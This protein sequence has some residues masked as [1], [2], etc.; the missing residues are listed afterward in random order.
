MLADF[1]DTMGT[2]VAI[3]GEA[4]LLDKEGNPPRT[5]QILVVDSIGAAAG[6]MGG[7]SSATSYVESSAGVGEGARTGLA[8]TVTGILFLLSMFLAPLVELVPSEAASTALVA[9]GFLMMTQVT[10][11]EWHRP[12]I[13]IPSFLTI[14]LMPFAYSITVGIGAGFVTYLIIELALGKVKKIHPLMWIV[15]LLFVL[16]FVLG[17]LQGLLGV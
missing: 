13:A 7:V 14:A 16:Y 9:V 2:M 12:E 6:G 17:P 11:I 8:T 5:R 10:E 1:F 3:G 15:S 4:D